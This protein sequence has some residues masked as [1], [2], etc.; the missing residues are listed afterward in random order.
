MSLAPVHPLLLKGNPRAGAVAQ[1]SEIFLAFRK[2]W[3][4]AQPHES[5]VVVNTCNPC[6]MGME[7]VQT[8]ELRD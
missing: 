6:A 3:A 7:C 5:D 1:L 4:H 2:P 8:G